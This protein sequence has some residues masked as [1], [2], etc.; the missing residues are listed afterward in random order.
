LTYSLIV[1]M[2]SMTFSPSS[3]FKLDNFF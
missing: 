1:L 2:K 3:I